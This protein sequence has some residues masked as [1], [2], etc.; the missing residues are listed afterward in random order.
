MKAISYQLKIIEKKARPVI[1]RRALI[2]YGITFSVLAYLLN[3]IMELE[4][5]D[6]FQMVFANERVYLRE[7]EKV[8]PADFHTEIWY[9]IRNA[10][11]T[12]IEDYFTEGTWF[13]YSYGT[14]KEYRVEIEKIESE[15]A[16]SIPMLLGFSRADPLSDADK[17]RTKEH[18]R[19]LLENCMCSH[20]DK[21]EFMSLSELYS[22]T[23]ETGII[24]LPAMKEPQSDEDNYFSDTHQ[25][26][27]KIGDLINER[28]G[29]E[30]RIEVLEQEL[31]KFENLPVQ[32]KRKKPVMPEEPVH[33][34]QKQFFMAYDKKELLKIAKGM[35]IRVTSAWKKSE[36][37]EIAANEVLRPT[38]FRKQL[39]QCS[40]AELEMF[41]DLCKEDDWYIP[42]EEEWYLLEGLYDRLLV[43]I[44]VQD[45]VTVSVEMKKLFEE[46][47]TR[48]F[49]Y[50]HASLSWFRQCLYAA[51]S[52]YGSVP[53]NV[54]CKLYSQKKGMNIDQAETE[55]LLAVLSDENDT[56]VL[57]GDRLVARE[58]T[59]NGQYK[60][61]EKEQGEK[62][63]YI[64]DFHEIEM[65]YDYKYPLYEPDY[66][67]YIAFLKDEFHIDGDPLFSVVFLTYRCLAYGGRISDVIEMLE[68]RGLVFSGEKA[69]RDFAPMIISLSNHTRMA[70]NCGY[71]PIELAEQR[72]VLSL[73]KPVKK[74]QKVYPNDPCPCGS[75]KKYKKC[76]GRK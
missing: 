55:R 64:P 9:D 49:R 16:V 69:V 74:M 29:I 4:E 34:T 28:T 54:F 24:W 30:K 72:R 35:N 50:E 15:Y 1:W 14:E 26:L 12:F 46:I 48:D 13:T 52:M 7:S 18:T 59:M 8:G 31:A 61:L 17:E 3:E 58:L 2:P 56:A 71:T 11:N 67:G 57:M 27:K 22:R 33:L 40:E 21:A 66:Q 32:K 37:A 39:M 51:C 60:Q 19:R 10:K 53:V 23:S 42:E 75:G 38:V 73:N 6:F 65:L 5:P 20:K 43:F 62:E 68:N 70:P 44:E 63:F 45:R 47:D 41:R 76:C 36:L 25:M